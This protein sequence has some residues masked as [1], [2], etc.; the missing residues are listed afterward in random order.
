[1]LKSKDFL[2][3]LL[4]V[5]ALATTL[6]LALTASE[7][8]QSQLGE[9]EATV[10]SERATHAG[11]NQP[12]GYLPVF[13]LGGSTTNPDVENPN[14]LVAGRASAGGAW[15]INGGPV[16]Q[17]GNRVESV[18]AD[19]ALDGKALRKWMFAGDNSGFHGALI[20]QNLSTWIPPEWSAP[21]GTPRSY[22][23]RVRFRLSSD[24]EQ[25]P[26]R[27]K[28]FGYLGSADT[29]H[30]GKSDYIVSF[31]MG[32]QDNNKIQWAPQNTGT[33]QVTLFR[34]TA[35]TPPNAREVWWDIETLVT[36]ESTTGANDASVKMWVNGELFMEHNNRGWYPGMN[37]FQGPLYYGG[38]NFTVTV[39]SFYIDYDMYYIGAS[40]PI[41][42]DTPPTTPGSLTAT[43]VSTSQINLSWTAST[44]DVGVS[45]YNVYLNGS[46]LATTSDTSY[47]STGLSASTTYTYTVS[48]YDAVGNLSEQSGSVSATT[49]APPPSPS[50]DTTP[51]NTLPP[52]TPTPI[53]PIS[54][55]PASTP[56]V[57]NSA[58]VSLNDE[59]GLP[60]ITSLV[61]YGCL[62]G[63]RFSPT[64][65][66][67]CPSEVIS[68]GQ[69]TL[70]P[71]PDVSVGTL[72]SNTISERRSYNLGSTTLRNGSRSEAVKELQR[73]LNDTLNL[74]LKL[75]GILGP[76]TIAVIRKWQRDNGLVSDGLVGPRTKARMME[77]GR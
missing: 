10:V 44:D 60:S 1:M 14:F 3:D 22:Y 62:P 73:F 6:A 4:A 53:T 28:I 24:Y 42:P 61:V 48:A 39:P 59:T 68:A 57:T 41:P 50:P 43:A 35:A 71:S 20:T 37:G 40:A 7:L 72:T 51:P 64:T 69:A 77:V 63:Y 58:P 33:D 66:L 12:A 52:P 32:C 65:G 2:Y 36:T 70:A 49:D 16:S 47:S 75:D 11:P 15:D 29:G 55:P 9:A 8:R 76:K 30:I 46:P 18:D 67:A 5:L 56:S 34:T 25:H 13:V 54:V 38:S 27:V 21:L 31:C 74:G 45:G 26:G 23:W 17:D 19:G